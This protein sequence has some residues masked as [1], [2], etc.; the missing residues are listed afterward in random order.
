MLTCPKC[1]YEWDDEKMN[2]CKNC[3]TILHNYCSNPDCECNIN[4]V[5]PVEFNHNDCFCHI[6]GSKTTYYEAGLIQPDLK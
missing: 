5:E 6:C 2:Y 3:G 4:V 1:G